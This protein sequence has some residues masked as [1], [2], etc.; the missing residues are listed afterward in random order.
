ME[1]WVF[2]RE[3]VKHI[4][5][6][7]KKLLEFAGL[8]NLFFNPFPFNP[9]LVDYKRPEIKGYLLSS[10]MLLE[11]PDSVKMMNLS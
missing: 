6:R 10:I 3:Y 4:L 2:R 9:I 1:G 7:F 5:L 8:Q 11:K